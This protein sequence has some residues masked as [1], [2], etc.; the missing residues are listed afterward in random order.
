MTSNDT[1]T[2]IADRMRGLAQDLSTF[3]PDEVRGRLWE[4]A[5]EL[6]APAAPSW[7]PVVGGWAEHREHGRR[8]PV[9]RQRPL[10]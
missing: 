9:H 7:S 3:S 1:N 4:W 10:D 2:T 5:D 8:Y 6:D